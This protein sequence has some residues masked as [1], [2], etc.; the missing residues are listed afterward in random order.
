M[1]HVCTSKGG[2]AGYIFGRT[3]KYRADQAGEFDYSWE[4]DMGRLREVLVTLTQG[5]E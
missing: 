3:H 5:G 1:G 2:N 4:I